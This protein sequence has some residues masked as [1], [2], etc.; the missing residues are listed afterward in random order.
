MFDLE[1]AKDIS[2]EHLFKERWANSTKDDKPIY[3]NKEEFEFRQLENA[4][5]KIIKELPFLFNIKDVSFFNL[6]YKPSDAIYSDEADYIIKK[7]DR[8]NNIKIEDFELHYN[9][10]YHFHKY[11]LNE[12]MSLFIDNQYQGYIKLK[13]KS[14]NSINL[15][16]EGFEAFIGVRKLFIN[17]DDIETYEKANN[18]IINEP[19]LLDKNNQDDSYIYSEALKPYNDIILAFDKYIE[20]SDGKD[21]IEK[22]DIRNWLKNEYQFTTRKQEVFS[23][24]IIEEYSLTLKT[25]VNAKK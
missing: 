4:I 20:Q 24:L 14:I 12:F 16:E 2:L 22:Q 3:D 9:G 19:Q 15:K 18:I 8:I 21:D 1:S 13:L 10:D 23:D 25:G 6:K 7:I 17:L 5:N 11:T